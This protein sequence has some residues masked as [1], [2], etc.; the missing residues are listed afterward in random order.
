LREKKNPGPPFF[1]GRYRDWHHDF[2]DSIFSKPQ[3]REN[4]LP[5]KAEA[6]EEKSK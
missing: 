6:I 3:K 5:E 2:L 1:G 4:K